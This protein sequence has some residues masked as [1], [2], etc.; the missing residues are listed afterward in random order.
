MLLLSLSWHRCRAENIDSQAGEQASRIVHM[1]TQLA[2]QQAAVQEK[3]Q[4]LDLAV[5]GQNKLQVAY[6]DVILRCFHQTG[7][8]PGVPG[9][10]QFDQVQSNIHTV[11]IMFESWQDAC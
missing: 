4:L 6:L 3:Q 11:L 7:V 2:V 10:T 8:W 9:M 1:Q 5:D